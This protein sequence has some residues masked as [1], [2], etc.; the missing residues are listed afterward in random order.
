MHNILKENVNAGADGRRGS[1]LWP[2][3]LKTPRGTFRSEVA[4]LREVER[5]LGRLVANEEFRRRCRT[6]YGIGSISVTASGS[7]AST[8]VAG[9]LHW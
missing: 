9:N 1:L 7:I 4:P 2:P 8:T 5:D 6:R 3:L